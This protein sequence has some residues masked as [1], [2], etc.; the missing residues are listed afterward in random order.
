[1]IKKSYPVKSKKKDLNRLYE[2][3]INLCWIKLLIDKFLD[4]SNFM[5]IFLRYQLNL[6]LRLGGKSTIKIN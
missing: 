3:I 6:F 1:M 5:F 4:W 2:E